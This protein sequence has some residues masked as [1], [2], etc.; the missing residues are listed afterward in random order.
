MTNDALK[1]FEATGLTEEDL[2]REMARLEREMDA[3]RQPFV[4]YMDNRLAIFKEVQEELELVSGQNINEFLFDVILRKQV[5]HVKMLATIKKAMEVT[6]PVPK[7][8]H[9][10]ECKSFGIRGAC[11]A[12][13]AKQS[14]TK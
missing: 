14:A 5:A 11:P 8:K 13:L 9:S 6:K 2:A 10:N 1:M 12:C 7:P 4:R 3:G